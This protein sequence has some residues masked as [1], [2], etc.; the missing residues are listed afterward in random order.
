MNNAFDI[1]LRLTG[2]LALAIVLLTLRYKPW[3]RLFG[4]QLWDF[5]SSFAMNLAV[6]TGTLTAFLQLV[7]SAVSPELKN[8]TLM[9]A[10]VFAIVTASAPLV[11]AAWKAP[12]NQIYFG[13]VVTAVLVTGLGAFG[14]FQLFFG[15]LTGKGL[16]MRPA[17]HFAEGAVFVYCLATAFVLAKTPAPA[18]TEVAQL[19][20]PRAPDRWTLP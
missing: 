2:A 10:A 13:G 17:L 7:V 4:T 6:L 15:L 18:L 9:Q 19:E 16:T 1:P 8:L 3:G 11:A 5:S 20:S 14:Q 12:G